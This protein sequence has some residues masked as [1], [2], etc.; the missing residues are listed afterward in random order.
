[1]RSSLLFQAL[2]VASSIAGSCAAPS[3]GCSSDGDFVPGSTV[4]VTVGKDRYYLLY[5]PVNYDPEE[6]APLI[7]SFHGGS[8]IA[9]EQLRLDNL[10]STTFNKDYIVAYPN[11]V[12]VSTTLLTNR[13]REPT[14]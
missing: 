6:P 9:E 2:A 11:G 3:P 8:R 7:L 10:T 5:I 13:P 14:S 1:M 12:D 4:N